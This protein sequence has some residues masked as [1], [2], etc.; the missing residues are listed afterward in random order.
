MKMS[1]AVSL[2][3]TLTLLL[4]GCA[5]P[6]QMPIPTNTPAP[7][8]TAVLPPAPL[9]S[10]TLTA[11]ITPEIRFTRQCLP[12]QNREVVLNEVASG[13]IL[14][15]WEGPS[16]E[17]YESLSA[18]IDL[19]TGN[20]YQLPSSLYSE[21]SGFISSEASPDRKLYAKL[22]VLFDRNRGKPGLKY[23]GNAVQVFDARANLVTKLTFNRSDL[24]WL[25]WLDNERLII[26][27]E[28]YG[29]L[30]LVNPFTEEQQTLADE[31]PGLY[32]YEL[33]KKNF[34]W[35]PVVYSPDLKWVAYYSE[36]RDSNGY[37]LGYVLYDLSSKQILWKKE[38]PTTLRLSPDGEIFTLAT[39][40]TIDNNQLYLFNRSGQ[41]KTVLDKSLP[42][43]PG[44]MFSWSP[45]SRYIAFW[46]VESLM[47]YDRQM[48]WVFDTCISSNRGVYPRWSP[49][50]KQMIVYVSGYS[51]ETMLVDW[52]EKLSYKIKELPHDGIMF[53]WMNSIP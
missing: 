32:P 12:V 52:Q 36:Q 39:A 4:P 23:I 16:V 10:A 22:E 34:P 47:I 26:D 24:V 21:R 19:Q 27:T 43:E 6:A 41:L 37:F 3:L 40:G 44:G 1:F 45:D 50:S 7:T 42:H 2:L 35:Y 48:D 38:S 15:T 46:N 20:E 9:P 13:T 25:H 53:E 33:N 51:T 31:L 18:L 28:Q 14:V 11:T 30:L 8:A 17:Y 5:A 49:D 29:T